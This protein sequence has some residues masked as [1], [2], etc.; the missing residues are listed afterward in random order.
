M[1]MIL[2]CIESRLDRKV[3][4]QRAIKISIHLIDLVASRP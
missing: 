3:R 2:G 4:K 1:S